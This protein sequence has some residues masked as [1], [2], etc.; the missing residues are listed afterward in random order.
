ML[1]LKGSNSM[2]KFTVALLGESSVNMANSTV[3]QN[4]TITTKV[5][6]T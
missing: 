5:V 4:T 1:L 3:N 6:G 2:N